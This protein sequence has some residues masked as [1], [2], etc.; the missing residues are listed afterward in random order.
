MTTHFTMGPGPRVFLVVDHDA[1]TKCP[2]ARDGGLGEGNN[3]CVT[4]PDNFQRNGQ[5]QI[6]ST[7]LNAGSQQ[8]VITLQLTDATNRV[9][10]LR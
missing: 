3:R 4:C 6:F 5:C 7:V 8:P 2:Q 9:F 10:F 1:A